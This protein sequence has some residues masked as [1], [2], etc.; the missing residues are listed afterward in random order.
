MIDG[1]AGMPVRGKGDRARRSLPVGQT[2]LRALD[3]RLTPRLRAER[4]QEDA[5]SA[6]LRRGSSIAVVG[7]AAHGG[8]TTVA[9]LLALALAQYQGDREVLAVDAADAGDL[10]RR[11]AV[12]S[13]GSVDAVLSELGIRGGDRS[14]PA[15]VRRRWLRQQLSLGA[16]VML[17][18]TDPSAVAQPVPA[19]PLAGTPVSAT[20]FTPPSATAGL[21]LPTASS[22]SA[23]FPPASSSSPFPSASSSGPLPPASRSSAYLPPD[24]LPSA[25]AGLSSAGPPSVSA[26]LS[27]VG[28][29]SAGSMGGSTAPRLA[30]AEYVAT[31]R[32]VRRYVS[33]LVVDT[34]RLT[35][36]S[37]VPAVVAN[38]DRVVVVGPDD[39]QGPAWVTACLPWL[40]GVMRQRVVEGV[41][42]VLV[43]CGR[44][45]RG[46]PAGVPT[47][48][49]VPMF[50]LPFD[51]AIA[52]DGGPLVWSDLAV[53]TQEAISALAA[54]LVRGLA[55]LPAR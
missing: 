48:L 45:S 32:A 33:V 54:R 44:P 21:P 9:A 14:G 37:V 4:G 5:L 13:G 43:E 40:A 55:D 11:L 19:P 28:P 46:G 52:R 15:V 8:R 6:R 22:S 30:A 42:G 1:R 49:D 18:A 27:L 36:R 20:P 47:D 29:P 34:P 39:G 23:P 50:R 25:S 16:R 10:Y 24:S 53:P 3:P 17:L 26:G 41:V 12:R 2:I 31:A 51:A 38:A 7:G 35:N